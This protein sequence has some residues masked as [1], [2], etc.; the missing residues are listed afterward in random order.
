M[1]ARR[2][3]WLFPG[4]ASQSV[5]MGQDLTAVWPSAR[6]LF[7]SAREQLGFD[8]PALCYTGPMEQL[9]ETRNAQPA[10]LLHSLSVAT[11]LR[12]E[13]GLVPDYVAGHSLGE[14]SAAAAVGA[15]P[16]GDAL[17][18]VRRRGELMFEAGERVPGTMAAVLGLSI[19]AIDAVCRQ[20]TESGEHG[21]V[22]LANI[23]SPA[24][25]VISGD[26]RAVQ[27]ADAALKDAGARRVIPLPVSGAFHS[28]LM[29]VLQS[30]FSEFLEPMAV[31]DPACPVVTNITAGPVTEAA[32]LKE[33]FVEQLVSPVRWHD[34]VGWM[35]AQGVDL[36]IEVGPGNVLTALGSKSFRDAEFHATA[37]A[38]G[39][40]KVLATLSGRQ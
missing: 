31:R 38:E 32:R 12:E 30:E 5:G 27:A 10:I 28:P 26:V 29:A 19:E 15:L 11:I 36:F 34:S 13:L 21:R 40:Q 6:T 3:A 23:N 39:L 25:L 7:D 22:V 1:T 18:L 14:I 24:Q 2:M 9:T 35:V 16:A 8:L 37:T 20:I 33:G 17:R 4:Q